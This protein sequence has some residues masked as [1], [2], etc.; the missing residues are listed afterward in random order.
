MKDF[1]KSLAI[2][3]CMLAVG[4]CTTAKKNF[5]LE[6]ITTN[7]QSLNFKE[8]MQNFEKQKVD[9]LQKLMNNVIQIRMKAKEKREFLTK[10]SLSDQIEK[11]IRENINRIYDR[12]K[13]EKIYSNL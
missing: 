1:L 5:T 10:K 9:N 4:N 6:E 8:E 12:T 11:N 13:T 3:V 7:L 2:G